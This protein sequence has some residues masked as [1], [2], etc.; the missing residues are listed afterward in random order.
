MRAAIRR[1][2]MQLALRWRERSPRERVLLAVGMGFLLLVGMGQ[3]GYWIH[4]TRAHLTQALP[5]AQARL[6]GMQVHVEEYLRLRA[7]A[8]PRRPSGEALLGLLRDSA[9]ESGVKLRL[10]MTDSGVSVVG[11]GPA[12][13]AL[14]WL[15][16]AQRLYGLRI[17]KLDLRGDHFVASLSSEEAP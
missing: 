7:E 15:A 16:K 8:V 4:R 13:A 17:A 2:A 5:L 3:A 9:A 14:L 1:Q 11:E 10:E 6:A 12:D